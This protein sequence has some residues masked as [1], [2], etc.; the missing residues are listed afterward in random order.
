MSIQLTRRVELLEAARE[1]DR[2]RIES[3]ERRVKELEASRRQPA[4]SAA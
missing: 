1:A 4:K 3:L 2:L